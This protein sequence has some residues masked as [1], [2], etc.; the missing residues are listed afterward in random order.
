MT[1]NICMIYRNF[2]SWNATVWCYL[3]MSFLGANQNPKYMESS[4]MFFSKEE[5]KDAGVSVVFSM[6]IVGFSYQ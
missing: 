2:L 3:F 1:C 6:H 5:L 4:M